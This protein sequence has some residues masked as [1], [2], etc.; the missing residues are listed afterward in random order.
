M[1]KARMRL[2]IEGQVQ[3]VF[4]RAS[5]QAEARRLDLQG[6]IRNRT[7]GSVEAL[8][9]GDKGQLEAFAAWCRRGPREARVENVQVQW[10]KYRGEF[11]DFRVTG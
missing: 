6:W 5:A 7:D 10:E 9:E 1:E 11:Q 4:F 2:A 3:G 8:A